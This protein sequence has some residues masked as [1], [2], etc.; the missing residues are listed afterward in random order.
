MTYAVQSKK[1]LENRALFKL[2]LE[3]V[4]PRATSAPHFQ[5]GELESVI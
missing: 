5:P 4:T 2:D 3:D 1:T